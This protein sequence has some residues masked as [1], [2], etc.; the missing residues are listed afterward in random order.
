M[1]RLQRQIIDLIPTLHGWC[2]IP[3][4][5]TLANLVLAQR[6]KVVLEIGVWGGRSLIP[7]LLAQHHLNNVGLLTDFRCVAIDPWHPAASVEGQTT[8]AD[9]EWWRGINHELVFQHFKHTLDAIGSNSVEI[10]RMRS[11]EADP[12]KTIDLLSVD[13]NHGQQALEDVCKFAPAVPVGGICVLDDIGWAGGFVGKSVEWLLVNGFIQ[14]HP[15][16]TGAVFFR[17]K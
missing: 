7:M 15:L 16:G 2:E 10:W 12:P 11:S 3:K 8:D 13:G 4:A 1:N 9:R 14:L 17:T 5:L 6:P